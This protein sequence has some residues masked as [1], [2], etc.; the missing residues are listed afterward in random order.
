MKIIFLLLLL[1]MTVISQNF[2]ALR[3]NKRIILIEVPVFD[4]P[5]AQQQVLL[6]KKEIQQFPAYQ[7]TVIELT[8]EEQRI[9]FEELTT[10]T[11][12]KEISQFKVSLIGL[13]GGIK[14]QSSEV[15]TAQDFFDLINTMPMRRNELKKG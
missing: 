14:F 2:D 9:D 5:Q 1:P 8:T 12:K 15:T 7:L 4:N 11:K 13:D 10:R 6:L 3:W